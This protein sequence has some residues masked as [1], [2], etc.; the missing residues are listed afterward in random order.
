[1]AEDSCCEKI[2]FGVKCGSKKYFNKLEHV[3]RKRCPPR[4]SRRKNDIYVTNKSN[5]Q[6]QLAHCEKLIE[7]GE[8]EI[9]LHGLGAAIPR[10]VNLALQLNEK[11]RGTFDLYTETGTVQVVDDIE[12]LTDLAEGDIQTRQNSAIHIQL[13]RTALC[14]I[15]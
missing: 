13:I 9:I 3:I 4:S 12:P 7:N 10:T 6:G 5:F 14:G 1:M 11:M 2:V 8:N 15:H